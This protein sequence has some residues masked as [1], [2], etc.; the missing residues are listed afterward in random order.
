MVAPRSHALPATERG[1]LVAGASLVLVAAAVAFLASD[2][3]GTQRLAGV[4]GLLTLAA[5]AAARGVR[6]YRSSARASLA[7][8][9]GTLRLRVRP[10]RVR[11]AVTVLL[12]LVLPIGLMAA[13][14]ALVVWGWLPAAGVLVVGCF[15][16][17]VAGQDDAR[18]LRFATRE[19]DVERT[20]ERLCMRA[21]LPVPELHVHWDPSANAWTA[22]GRIHVTTELLRLLDARELEAVLAH[23]VGHL[24]RRDAAVMDIC[25][26]PARLLL[27]FAAHATRSIGGWSRALLDVSPW[28]VVIGWA[29]AALFVPVAFAVGWVSRLSVL[30]L[31]RARE[32]G[33]DA[34]A[35]ALT[36]SPSALGSALLKLERGQDWA[37][38]G[39]LRA[40]SVLCVVAAGPARL[41]RLLATHPR[42]SRRVEKLQELERR[43]QAGE[44][45]ARV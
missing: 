43:L 33:A 16:M 9:I 5:C 24:V 32:F 35:A 4:T 44:R 28:L 3:G 22:G 12:A 40:Q 26:A 18:A 14:V 30:S 8:S 25:S 34:A 27:G 21:D 19:P 10:L 17:T 39:D 20:L 42:T 37:P 2:P 11:S 29:F 13:A 41:G 31:S 6:L 23:E 45:L 7:M 15:A 36:G 38:A 1:L